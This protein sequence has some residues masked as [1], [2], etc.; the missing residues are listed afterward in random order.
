M[1]FDEIDSG[2]SGEVADKMGSLMKTIAN[3]LQV[4]TIT[5]LPQIASKANAHYL[6]FKL[7]DKEM[8]HSNIRRLNNEERVDEIAKMLSGEELSNAALENARALLSG[9]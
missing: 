9:K 5:H 8:A 1:I 6:A 4:I 3:S 2:V 7:S